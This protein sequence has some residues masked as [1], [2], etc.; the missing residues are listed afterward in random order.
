MDSEKPL[1]L[2]SAAPEISALA[3][4]RSQDSAVNEEIEE[5]EQSA[6]LDV[7]N[8]NQ[9]ERTNIQIKHGRIQFISLCFVLFLGGWTSG[10]TGALLPRIKNVYDVG[11][12]SP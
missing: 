10:T 11:L 6:G 1:S 4:S 2:V 7:A 12:C 5:K 9:P 8:H 3:R